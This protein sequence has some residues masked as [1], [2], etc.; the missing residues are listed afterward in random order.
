MKT[1]FKISVSAA[2]VL[3]CSSVSNAQDIHHSMYN[4]TP[5]LLNPARAGVPF[6]ARVIMNYKS[7][8]ASVADP[9]TTIAF[10][11][12][13]ATFKKKGN[14][15]YMGLGLTFFNDKAGDVGMKTTQG[16]LSLSGVL[17]PDAYNKFSVGLMGGFVQR[18]I[19]P[20][21]Q[22]WGEQYDGF[23]FNSALASGE[24][25]LLQNHNFVDMGAGFNWY[26]GKGEK[27]MTANDG[28]KLNLGFAVFHPHKPKYSYYG[29]A[30]Q[31]LDPKI[32]VHGWSSIGTG[33][34]N[35]CIEPSFLYLRQGALQEFTPGVNLKYIM[36]EGSKYT[37]RKKASAMSVGG[38]FRT[39]D[40][41]ILT[42][43]FEFQSYACGF[44]YDV[45]VSKLNTVSRARGGF[46][47]FLRMVFPNPFGSATNKSMI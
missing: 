25:S 14:K 9:Y 13:M 33:N 12:D 10:S 6:D 45:N 37:G 7:Q 29:V 42:T 26:Y 11:G 47:V 19:S 32:V 39:R 5:V 34:S 8:W 46:E 36:S 21:N 41:V 28:V 44:S 31:R 20:S 35:L 38:Y 15:S 2:V 24:T 40:A 18:G 16:S 43:M 27:Y 17:M 22:Q 1:I 23:Q 3:I 30:D 4:E